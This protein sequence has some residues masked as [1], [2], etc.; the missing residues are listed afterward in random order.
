MSLT[1]PKN[2]DDL[3]IEMIYNIFDDY[4]FS[5]LVK[6][7]LHPPNKRFYNLKILFIYS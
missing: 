5:D 4:E 1:N 7:Y 2:F 6:L 3:P